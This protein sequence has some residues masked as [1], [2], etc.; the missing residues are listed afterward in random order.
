[1]YV[2]QSGIYSYT[3]ALDVG[4]DCAQNEDCTASIPTWVPGGTTEVAD[5]HT[6]PWE[7][8][9][10]NFG[11]P[12]AGSEVYFGGVLISGPV[13]VGDRAGPNPYPTYV[14]QPIGGSF[15]VFVVGAGTHTNVCHLS[16]PPLPGVSPCQ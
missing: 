12:V 1:V 3:G 6:H 15:G 4:P 10:G 5:W 2:D 13:W 11:G 8:N 14:S 16:G 7:G 9:S